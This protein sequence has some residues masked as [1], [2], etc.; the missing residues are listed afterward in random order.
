MFASQINYMWF[1]KKLKWMKSYVLL[2]FILYVVP[3][4]PKIVYTIMCFHTPQNHF[5]DTT[6][7]D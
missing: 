5:Q 7:N 4:F 6:L 2:H 1:Q 3:I